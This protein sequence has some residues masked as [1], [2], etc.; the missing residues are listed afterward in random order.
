MNKLSERNTV[1]VDGNTIGFQFNKNSLGKRKVHN[2]VYDKTS[3]PYIKYLGRKIFVRS[4][5]G[6]NYIWVSICSTS[7]LE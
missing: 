1:F 6:S 7:N 5:C 4:V 2:K 3:K